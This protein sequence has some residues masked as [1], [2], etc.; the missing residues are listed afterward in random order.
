MGASGGNT[1][2]IGGAGLANISIKA[3]GGVGYGT[4]QTATGPYSG[5]NGG[6]GSGAGGSQLANGDAGPG[7]NANSTVSLEIVAAGGTVFGELSGGTYYYGGG[8][9]NPLFKRGV[10]YGGNP[11][12]ITNGG[13]N[14]GGGGAGGGGLNGRQSTDGGSGVVLIKT[15]YYA[16]AT[17]GSNL[18][19]SSNGY[20]Y[21]MF[22]GTGSI[23]F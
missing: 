19:V 22:T 20:Y 7:T 4:F 14:S 18:V 6:G 10:G 9:G 12:T 23:T 5:T 17:T 21:Y 13:I 1:T 15:P 8:G 2:F 11:N 3:T 16:N